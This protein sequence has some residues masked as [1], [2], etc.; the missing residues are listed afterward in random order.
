MACH[1]ENGFLLRAGGFVGRCRR[2][3]IG[4]LLSEV[5]VGCFH[6]LVT[7]QRVPRCLRRLCEVLVQE[8]LLRPLERL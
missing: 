1:R 7:R 3:A 5:P 2:D 6:V 8:A 4:V